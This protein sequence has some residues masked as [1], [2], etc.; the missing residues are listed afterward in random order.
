VR[1]DQDYIGFYL[2]GMKTPLLLL[3]HY[4]DASDAQ[5]QVLFVRGGYLAKAQTRGRLEFRQVCDDRTL[6]VALVHFEPR[7]PWWL[8]RFSQAIA[9]RIV[10]ARFRRHLR[11]VAQR[12]AEPHQR[13]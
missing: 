8:Y 13:E 2:W 6:L 11:R 9:H 5:R 4:A 12:C 3:S 1:S 7:L 10:M